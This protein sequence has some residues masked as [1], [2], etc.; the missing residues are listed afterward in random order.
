MFFDVN[1]SSPDA[2]A[3][4]PIPELLLRAIDHHKSIQSLCAVPLV[5]DYVYAK[6]SDRHIAIL[7]QLEAIS[8]GGAPT[9]D[10]VWAWCRSHC[11]P[12]ANLYGI[13]E[14]AGGVA[15]RGLTLGDGFTLMEGLMGVIEKE[16]PDDDSGELLIV[17]KVCS[18]ASPVYICTL[19]HS[20]LISV[21]H[22]GTKLAIVMPS[23]SFPL[24]MAL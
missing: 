5:M 3:G 21:F 6:Q 14:A 23:Q 12:L 11:I 19:S 13:T 4:L 24:V 18:D 1:V 17:S 9:S 20:W 7:Q 15:G 2:P 8:A 10:D 16:H 22:M